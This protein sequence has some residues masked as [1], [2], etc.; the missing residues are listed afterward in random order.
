V[1]DGDLVG[2]TDGASVGPELPTAEGV[3]KEAG[4]DEAD[5]ALHPATSTTALSS[6][7]K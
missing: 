1:T 7:L 5:D 6:P 4:A 2:I 3:G